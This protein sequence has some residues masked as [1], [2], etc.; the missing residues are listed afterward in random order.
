MWKAFT[1]VT[2]LLAGL[3]MWFICMIA[4]II[5]GAMILGEAVAADLTIQVALAFAPLMVPW[6]LFAPMRFLFDAWVKTLLVGGVGFLI[7]LLFCC[8]MTAFA[9]AAS[10]ALNATVGNSFESTK[11]IATFSPILLG[12]VVMIMIA[13]KVMSFA[14]SLVSGGGMSGL[15]LDSFKMA[16]GTVSAAAAAPINAARS[17]A[18]AARTSAETAR[19]GVGMA[20]A[21]LNSLRAV[22]TPSQRA[23]SQGA[24][25]VS[26]AAQQM[27][28]APGSA[29]TARA[30]A[31]ANKAYSAARF[32][33]KGR[34]EAQ[35]LARQAA[36]SSLATAPAKP[37]SHQE[38]LQ[39][40]REKAERSKALR[41][42]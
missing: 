42:S 28:K 18:S 4:Y 31:K 27:G 7:A 16:V 24:R 26:A 2:G 12:S 19:R 32:S 6:L 11:L 14:H 37:P 30:T 9:N 36:S 38:A 20:S 10:N 13:S 5:A 1:H 8:A 33:G 17:T 34:E 15:S 22:G 23:K 21:G 29:E 35:T 25:A 3:L 40:M 39:R 41:R